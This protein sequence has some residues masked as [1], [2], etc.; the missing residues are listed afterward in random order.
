MCLVGAYNRE[1]LWGILA[2][3][4]VVIAAVYMLSLVRRVVF[5][6]LDPESAKMPD[7]SLRETLILVAILVFVVWMGVY[8]KTFLNFTNSVSEILYTMINLK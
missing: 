2:V 1:P 6:R 7:L 3:P 5:G 8:P 4:G